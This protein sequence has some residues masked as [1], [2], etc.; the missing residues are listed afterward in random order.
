MDCM[1]LLMGTLGLLILAIGGG[2]LGWVIG[3][4]IDVCIIK[5][6]KQRS[7]LCTNR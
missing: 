6:Y 4:L 2:L 1:G 3:F 5:P 7:K